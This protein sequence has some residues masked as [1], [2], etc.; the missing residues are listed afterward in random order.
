LNPLRRLASQTAIYGLST[1]V[2]RLLNY[3]LVPLYTRVFLPQEYGVVSV[4]Y[5]FVTFAYVV[6]T[7]GME[8]AF[9]RHYHIEGDKERVYDTSL[10]SIIT[11]SVILAGTMILFSDQIAA[12]IKYP[13]KGI[14]VTWF[15]LILGLDAIVAIP[16][17]K[18]RAEHKAKRFASVK[19]L[20]IMFN[21][22]FNLFFLVL[23][24]AILKGHNE[25]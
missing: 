14:Y 15:A 17:N 22:F 6:Y 24:P 16:F 18:L 2:G 12:L 23:C 1:I 9:F 11:S 21:I 19:F 20:N 4:M 8:T 13:G 3:F 7:Y 25:T 10:I 5:A